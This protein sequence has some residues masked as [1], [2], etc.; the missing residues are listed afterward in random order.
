MVPQNQKYATQD[1]KT[2][3]RLQRQVW[4]QIQQDEPELAEKIRG[5][6]KWG[7]ATRHKPTAY[8]LARRSWDRMQREDPLTAD[9]I[10]S[11]GSPQTTRPDI[12]VVWPS[13]DEQQV[14]VDSLRNGPALPIVY[15]KQGLHQEWKYGLRA[16][17]GLETMVE[18]IKKV[19]WMVRD[20]MLV[21]DDNT[22]T[23]P[24]DVAAT[25]DRDT[26]AGISLQPYTRYVM[27][28]AT[29]VD[30]DTGRLRIAVY[31]PGFSQARVLAKEVY[32]IVLAILQESKSDTYQAVQHWYTKRVGQGIGSEQTIEQAFADE[33]GLEE[34]GA[35][36]SLSRGVV[37]N[38][39]HI[40]SK[41]AAVLPET[42]SKVKDNWPAS[43]I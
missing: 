18:K 8:K 34:T 19:D 31:R 2:A 25:G 7:A 4:R 5:M 9:Q 35:R 36:S 16:P 15:P 17:K 3:Q 13:W 1:L 10:L 22:P 27:E 28:A 14:R 6:R 38:A 40:F 29:S 42:M 41:N 32:H 39:R 33:M 43:V 26:R 30:N 20:T 24:A 23:A 21:F 37:K 11:N 12:D